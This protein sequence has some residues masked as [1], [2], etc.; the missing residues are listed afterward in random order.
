ARVL[1]DLGRLD[2]A[3]AD[4]A[5]PLDAAAAHIEEALLAVRKL[6]EGIDAEPGRLEAIDERL[7]VITRLKRKY[8]DS[9]AA[10]LEFHDA[11][12]RELE[13][14][15]H[16]DEIVAA[17]ERRASEILARLKAVALAVS[18]TR[19]EAA[20]RLQPRIQRELRELGMER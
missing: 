5:T 7:D 19:R 18:T 12:V 1:G 9:E 10:M 13:R 15:Q 4:A 2:G 6:L 16:H 3:F 11:I 14:L 17:A 20:A 8:G